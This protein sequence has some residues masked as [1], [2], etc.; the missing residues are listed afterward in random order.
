R[1][2]GEAVLDY[3]PRGD[4]RL[5]SYGVDYDILIANKQQSQPETTTRVTINRGTAVL[6]MEAVQTTTYEIRNKGTEK[7]ALIIEHPRLNNRKLKGVE[8][9]ETTDSF[10]RFR[11]ALNSGQATELAVP[12]IVARQTTVVL[13]N[14]TRQQL[15]LF[16]GKETP[17]AVRD[18]LGQ[19]VDFQEQIATMR[20]DIASTQNNIDSLF[21]D[22]ERLRE[23]I[24][25]LRDG[26]EEQQL[27]T[28]YL[29]QLKKQEDQIDA[30]R[31]HI[32]S[33]NKDMNTTQNKLSDL[34]SNLSFGG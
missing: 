29:D 22:Q 30:G 11:V 13:G 26:A 7:K 17:Q 23:N 27:R 24:K 1:Y 3:M 33:V 9:F 34:I 32:E 18:K 12:E 4:K 20:A 10:Y 25:A 8:P 14:L 19:I 28:R 31:A 6:F 16:S 5:V 2:S 15:V 21:R